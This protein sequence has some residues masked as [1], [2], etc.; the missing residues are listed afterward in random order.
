MRT[1]ARPRDA[2]RQTVSWLPERSSCERGQRCKSALVDGATPLEWLAERASDRCKAISDPR[3]STS[4]YEAGAVRRPFYLEV[5]C[6]ACC[7]RKSEIGPKKRYRSRCLASLR[8]DPYVTAPNLCDGYD[9][10]V[11]NLALG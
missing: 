4:A 11:L 2:P 6:E 7:R 3:G 9:V 8:T 1:A 10:Q 5:A